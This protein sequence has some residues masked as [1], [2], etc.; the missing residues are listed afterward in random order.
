MNAD[1]WHTS[2]DTRN[3][4][5]FF[6]NG[7]TYFGSASLYQWNNPT[8]TQANMVLD[9][10]GNLS[11]VGNINSGGD[12]TAYSDRRFKTNIISVSNAL[13]TVLEMRGV[14]YNRIEPELSSIR[15]L[16]VIAQELETVLP[17]VVNT[18]T[19]VKTSTQTK[20]VAYGNITAILIEA[21]KELNQKVDALLARTA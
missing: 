14:F 13:S 21:I 18:D 6:T 4:F 10:N 5:F 12:V 15:K 8:N 11:N 9:A 19:D 3:R 20:S 17:E 7:A 2:T 16:G 1:T